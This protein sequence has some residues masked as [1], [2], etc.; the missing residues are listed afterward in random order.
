MFE[1]KTKKRDVLWTSSNPGVATVDGEGNAALLAPGTSTIT[2]SRGE[3]RAS[4]VLTVTTAAAPV[5]SA[6]PRDTNVSAVI[7][8][9]TG[10]QVQ[11]LD[12]LGGPLPGQSIVVS[13]STNPPVTGVL[14][15]TSSQITDATGTATF[16]DLKIDWLGSGYTLMAGANP[17]SGAVAG[18]SAAFNERR[19]GDPCLGPDQPTCSSGCP[20]ISGDG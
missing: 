17:I 9:G 15:G 7:D 18:T 4:T 6:Q 16:P 5:F 3:L 12:N 10:V 14:S 2:A 19:V 11:L 20:N 8:A 13:I 1:G